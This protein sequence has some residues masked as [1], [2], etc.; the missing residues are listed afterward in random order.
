L[1]VS[2]ADFHQGSSSSGLDFNIR[3]IPEQCSVFG[4]ETHHVFV[5]SE[6]PYDSIDRYILY[7]AMKTFQIPQK[8]I[9]M[10]KAAMKTHSA[11]SEL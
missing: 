4:I 8:P 9:A 11:R 3:Q 7:T 6:A 5:N 1:A 2:K 10:A